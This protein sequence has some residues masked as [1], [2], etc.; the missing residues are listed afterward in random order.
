MRTVSAGSLGAGLLHA[1]RWGLLYSSIVFSFD[2]PGTEMAAALICWNAGLVAC[3]VTVILLARFTPFDFLRDGVLIP[4]SLLGMVG[5]LLIATESGTGAMPSGSTWVGL[6]MCSVSMST[7]IVAWS[8]SFSSMEVDQVKASASLFIA[9]GTIVFLV[10]SLLPRDIARVAVA[11][12]PVA[13]CALL[14]MR[15]TV[16]IVS[17]AGPAPERRIGPLFAFALCLLSLSAANSFMRGL[18]LTVV[19]IDGNARLLFSAIVAM[20]I[21]LL[22]V[23]SQKTLFIVSFLAVATGLELLSADRGELGST[24][25]GLGF[26]CFEILLWIVVAETAKK[27]KNRAAGVAAVVWLGLHIGSII[28]IAVGLQFPMSGSSIPQ[29]GRTA[30]LVLL[31]F[32]LC[33]FALCFDKGFLGM[34]DPAQDSD[35]PSASLA[36]HIRAFAARYALSPRETEI[37]AVLARGMSVKYIASTMMLSENTVKTHVRSIYK[38]AGV[39]TRDQLIDRIARS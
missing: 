4:A 1:W 26:V 34:F 38:K 3:Y 20:C 10:C 21:A 25:L 14:K 18:G 39:N 19:T 2:G 8:E 36:N 13:S 17:S 22:F 15:G 28:G 9:F 29:M 16:R 7:L 37:C 6:L 35:Q 23:R 30:S 32:V 5:T 27:R 33:G 24:I 31:F 12:C 11:L